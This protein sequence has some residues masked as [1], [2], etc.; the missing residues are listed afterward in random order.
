MCSHLAQ[1]ASLPG[2]AVVPDVS[3]QPDIR[4]FMQSTTAQRIYPSDHFMYT[5]RAT[6]K[7]PEF[8][9]SAWFLP[10]NNLYR[11]RREV[12]PHQ[13]TPKTFQRFAQTPSYCLW[14]AESPRSSWLAG[15]GWPPEVPTNHSRSGISCS[16]FSNKLAGWRADWT[17]KMMPVSWKMQ[18]CL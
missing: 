11:D 16:C 15:T 18:S 8:A 12:L 7:K 2:P 17:T 6:H 5:L 13:H 4:T 1:A 10:A 14:N 9:L 3:A